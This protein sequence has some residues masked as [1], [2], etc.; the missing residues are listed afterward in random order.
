VTTG[1]TARDDNP[2]WIDPQFLR[3]IAEIPHRRPTILHA[4]EDGVLFAL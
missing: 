2:F 1:R 4:I 3:V